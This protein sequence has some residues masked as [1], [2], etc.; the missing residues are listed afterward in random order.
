MQRSQIKSQIKSYYR[1]LWQERWD[2]TE[3]LGIKRLIPKLHDEKKFLMTLNKA[4][5]NLIVQFATG[6]GLFGHHLH[7]WRPNI[8]STCHLC[9]EAEETAEHLLW[10]CAALNQERMELQLH[11]SQS[12]DNT[13]ERLFV[14]IKNSK[15]KK[16]LA[17]NEGLIA[18][19]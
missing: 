14:Y 10:E 5:I 16:I 7:H 2:N 17:I 6:H 8:D 19:D 18:N 13:L 11:P 3:L 9:E 1:K 15:I 4:N 12:K